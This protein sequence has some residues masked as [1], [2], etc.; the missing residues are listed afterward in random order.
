MYRRGNRVNRQIQDFVG[1]LIVRLS[2]LSVRQG[3]R[4]SRSTY[5]PF[6][7]NKLFDRSYLYMWICYYEYLKDRVNVVIMDKF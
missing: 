7:I 4:L 5:V 3:T 1:S 2:E 6:P